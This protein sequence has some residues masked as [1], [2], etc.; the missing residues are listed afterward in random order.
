MKDLFC[1]KCG[2]THRVPL[3]VAERLLGV[4]HLYRIESRQMRKNFNYTYVEWQKPLQM[5]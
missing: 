3:L 5:I 2:L 1:N 4:E